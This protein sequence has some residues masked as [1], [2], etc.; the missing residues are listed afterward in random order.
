MVVVNKFIDPILSEAV[1]KKR[2]TRA[3]GE[4]AEKQEPVGDRE[5]NDGETLLD[6]LVNYTEGE[7]R[8]SRNEN[9]FQAYSGS[10]D[11][12]ILR[13]EILNILIAGRDT[14]GGIL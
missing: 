9:C 10:E 1:A 6:H 4:A 13:D 7:C 5:V 14:V 2:A 3:G 8:P 11:Q 12:T